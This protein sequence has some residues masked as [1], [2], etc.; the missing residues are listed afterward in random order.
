MIEPYSVEAF[1]L[2]FE[3]MRILAN[4]TIPKADKTRL[5]NM[6]LSGYLAE[7]QEEFADMIHKREGG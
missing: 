2:A 3:F 4:S 5:R 7:A 6:A 1:N